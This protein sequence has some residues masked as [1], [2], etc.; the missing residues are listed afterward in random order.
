MA[1]KVSSGYTFCKGRDS[2]LPIDGLLVGQGE[3]VFQK[4][5]KAFLK[6]SMKKQVAIGITSGKVY[7]Y[8]LKIKLEKVIAIVNTIV[9]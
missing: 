9:R 5:T 6:Y 8:P 3:T 7:V 1:Y 4:T 2:R